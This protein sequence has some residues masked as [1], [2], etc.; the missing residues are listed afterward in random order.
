LLPLGKIGVIHEKISRFKD[1]KK[2]AEAA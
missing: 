2:A 1:K